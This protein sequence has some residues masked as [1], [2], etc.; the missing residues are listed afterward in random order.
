MI[1]IYKYAC[2]SRFKFTLEL[3]MFK[4]G[5][6]NYRG[7]VKEEFVFSKINILIGENSA[8]KSSIFKFLLALKQSLRAPNNRDSNLTFSGVDADLGNYKE[9]IYNHEVKK[10][11]SFYF[12]FEKDYFDFFYNQYFAYPFME[13][14]EGVELVN[15]KRREELM[16]FLDGEV[17][18]PTK[19][20]FELSKELN[21]HRNINMVIE[22]DKIGMVQVI[23]ANGESQPENDIYLIN[24]SP[25]CSLLFVSNEESYLFENVSYSKEGFLSII[26][27]PSL[28]DAID[29]NLK[30]NKS[31]KNKKTIAESIFWRLAYLFVTQ[32]YIQKQLSGI[33]YINPLLSRPAERI[34][35]EGD[36]KNVRRTG[37]IKDLVD[38]LSA[39]DSNKKFEEKLSNALTNF[40]IADKVYVKN[41]GF[42][43]ELRVV[44]NGID[45]NI[46]DVGFGVSLQLPIFAQSI[47]S[48]GWA[49]SSSGDVLQGQTLLIEQPEVH[50]HPQLQAKFIDALIGISKRNRYI[51]ETHSEHIIR[52]LQIIVKEKRHGIRGSDISITYLRKEGR[53]MVKTFHA[54]EEDSGKLKPLF[55]KGFY[56][57]SYNLAFELMS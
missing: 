42:T 5:L 11:L 25:T 43:R 40:G 19:I 32:N 30:G 53:K 23:H 1:A 35:L 15:R 6:K 4:L 28:K 41:V 47:I 39:N 48:D 52:M 2:Q 3:A 10:N 13:G 14:D 38:F 45:S 56:D 24:E 17:E 54:I 7:F 26:N 50:L 31:L 29:A 27:S 57:V 18:E 36:K 20:S 22:N 44:V 46:K 16:G 55:P 12:E 37:D 9:T 49:K 33:E 21:N 34:Y 51:I 8:G